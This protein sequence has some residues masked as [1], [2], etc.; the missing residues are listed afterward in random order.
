MPPPGY[1]LW[2][3]A[4]KEKIVIVPTWRGAPSAEGEFKQ[5]ET[6]E[7]ISKRYSQLMF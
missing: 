5:R 6:I 4:N 3:W 2:H 7:E 1:F